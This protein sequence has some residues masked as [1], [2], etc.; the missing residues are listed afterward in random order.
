M[1]KS[2]Q[3]TGQKEWISSVCGKGRQWIG[4]RT[5]TLKSRIKEFFLPGLNYKGF[6]RIE[7]V[8]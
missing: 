4:Q 1:Q 3:M 5:A 8:H 7:I 6:D 2:K